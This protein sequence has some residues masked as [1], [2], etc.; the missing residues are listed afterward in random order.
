[1]VIWRFSDLVELDFVFI[2]YNPLRK[3]HTICG[4]KGVLFEKAPFCVS[5]VW[6]L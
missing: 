3:R 4:T 6:D 1:M 2:L 5:V